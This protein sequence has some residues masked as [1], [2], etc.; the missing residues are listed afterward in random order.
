MAQ[1]MNGWKC[2]LLLTLFADAAPQS[3]SRIAI[4]LYPHEL[5]IYFLFQPEGFVFFFSMRAS[6]E[7]PWHRDDMHNV[8][9][10]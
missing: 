5:D 6:F 9:P 7:H 4:T 1:P 10:L 2:G 8:R 3:I